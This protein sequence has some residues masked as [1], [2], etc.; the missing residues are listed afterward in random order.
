MGYAFGW[1]CAEYLLQRSDYI[2][3]H[4]RSVWKGNDDKCG[5]VLQQGIGFSIFRIK[6]KYT[7][8]VA[9]LT[10]PY[11]TVYLALRRPSLS[12][13]KLTKVILWKYI[14]LIVLK[15]HYAIITPALPGC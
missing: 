7:S 3:H 4:R 10:F 6:G 12:Y 14:T 9:L 1:A 15:M 5:I 13:K 2:F 11:F 8:M